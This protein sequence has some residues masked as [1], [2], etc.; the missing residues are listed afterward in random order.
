[1]STGELMKNKATNIL[2]VL[3]I[4]SIL[5]ISTGCGRTTTSSTGS[6]TVAGREITYSVDGPASVAGTNPLLIKFGSHKLEK[7]EGNFLLDG[8]NIGGVGGTERVDL[9]VSNSILTIRSGGT[10]VTIPFTR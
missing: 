10:T 1:M 3:G 2:T 4:S 5:M 8:R 6:V 9:V 7:N